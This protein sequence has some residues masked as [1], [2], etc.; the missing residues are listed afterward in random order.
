MGIGV[1]WE[2]VNSLAARVPVQWSVVLAASLAAACFDLRRRRIPNALTGPVFLAG[3]VWAGWASGWAGFGESLGAAAVVMAPFVALFAFGGGG[4]GD[5][6]LMAALGAWLG[7]HDGLTALAAVCLA[8]GA[9]GLCMAVATGR[10][11]R[12]AGNLRRHLAGL[13]IYVLTCGLVGGPGASDDA[14]STAMPYGVAI[15]LGMCMTMA[16]VLL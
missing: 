9:L 1:M 4:A 15:F 6:K 3:I 11:G 16:W 7:F 12:V 2:A 8:G 10:L 14:P 5:A 13:T